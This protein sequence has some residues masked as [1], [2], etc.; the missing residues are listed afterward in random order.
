MVLATTY[1]SP[2]L[3]SYVRNV[4][5]LLKQSVWSTPAVIARGISGP[6]S[7]LPKEHFITVGFASNYAVFIMGQ[8][9]NIYVPGS[10]MSTCA[11]FNS[12]RLGL[13][14]AA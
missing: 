5:P 7:I 6:H 1:V 10:S 9:S 4:C 13:T 2:T 14:I 11:A 3:H 12:M 8:I